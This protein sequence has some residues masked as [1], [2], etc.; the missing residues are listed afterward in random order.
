MPAINV[1][2]TDTFE[3]QRIKINEISSQIFAIGQGGSDL[4]TGN[5]KLGDGSI[6]VPSLTFTNDTTLGLYRPANGV[7]QWAYNSKKL[8]DIKADSI[9]S[10]RDL[11]VEQSAINANGI[12]IF[13]AGSNYDAGTYSAIN[14]NGGSG[15]G[16]FADIVVTAYAGTI[17]EDGENY[18]AGTYTDIA[19]AGGN[20]SGALVSFVVPPIEGTITNAGS[21]YAPGTYS[22]ISLTTTGGVGSGATADIEITG[23]TTYTGTIA[24]SGS[25]YAEDTYESVNT[26]N[27]PTTTYTVTSVA[28]PGTP[29]PDN[30][31]QINGSTQPTLSLIRGNTYRFDVSDA[32]VATH[33]LSFTQVGGAPLDINDY[34]IQTSGVQ[35]EAGSFVDLV[36]KETA[37]IGNIEYICTSHDNMGAQ[38]GVG[39]GVVGNDGTGGVVTIAVNASGNVSSVT[40][41]QAGQGYAAGDQIQVSVDS[42]GGQGSGFL[43]TINSIVYTGIVSNVVIQGNGQNYETGDTLSINNA[44]TGNSGSGFEFTITSNPGS[45]TDLE[46]SEKGTNYQTGDTLSL[47]GQVTGLNVSLPGETT[48][49]AA[50]L[51]TATP[52]VTVASTAN[53]I[54]GMSVETGPDDTGELDAGTTVASIING[55]TIQLS[56]NPTNSG[57]ATLSFSSDSTTEFAVLSTTGIIIGSTITASGNGQLA[58][59]TT[60]ESV[61]SENNTIGISQPPDAAGTATLTIT[62]PFGDPGTDWQYEVGTLGVIESIIASGPGTGYVGGDVLTINDVDLAQP[63]TKVVTNLALI[64]LT[65]SNTVTSTAFQVGDTIIESTSPDTTATV[66]FIKTTGGNID[67]MLITQLTVDSGQSINIEGNAQTYTVGTV[68]DTNRYYIDGALTPNLTLYVGDTYRFDYSDGSN[69]GHFFA[70]SIF[71]D[72]NHSPSLVSVAG[73]S[74]VGASDLITVS[75]T[76]GIQVGMSVAVEA[77][78]GTLQNGTLVSE[79]VDGTTVR[80]DR[81]ALQG[82]SAD[83]VFAGVEYTSGVDRQDNYVDIKITDATPSLYYYCATEGTEHE[84]EA[85]ADNEEAVITIDPNN[86]RV[87]GSGAEFIV[88]I[89]D[90]TNVFSADVETG[91]VSTTGGLTTTDINSTSVTNTG[92]VASATVTVETEIT[93]PKVKSTGALQLEASVSNVTGNFNVGQNLQITADTGNF[94][95]SGELKTTGS[96]N[97]NDLLFIADNDISTPANT[98]ISFTPPTG[99]VAKVISTG[100]LTIPS[101]TTAERPIVGI[102][103]NGSIRFNTETGQYEGYSEATTQWSSLG[104]VRDL[105]GNT[106]IKAEESVGSNDNTLWFINDDDLTVKF[107][108]TKLEFVQNKT[109]SSLNQSAPAY[110]DWNANTPVTLGQYLKYKQNLYEVTGAGTTAGSASPPTHNSGAVV[111]G[112]ATLTFWGLA[113][114]ALTFEDITEVRVG[115]TDDTALVVNADLRL[116]ENKVI[117]DVSDLVFAPNTG[118]KIVVDAKTSLVLPTGLTT[119]RGIP[120]QGSVRFNTQDNIFEGY[121]GT[122][123]GSLGGVKDVDQDTYITP[124]VSAGSD[125]DVLYFY[126]ANNNTL[127]LNTQALDFYTIDTVRSLTSDEFELTASLLTID[128]AATTLD[129]GRS[130]TTFLHS[131]KQ[132]FEIG[133]SYGLGTDTILKLD[134]QGDLFFNTGF[135]SGSKTELKLLNK[136]LTEFELT[137]F[138]VFTEKVN[139]IKGTTDNGVSIVYDAAVHEGA[140]VT[141]VAHNTSTNSKEFFE[142]GI[143]DDGTNVFYTEYGNIATGAKIVDLDFDFTANSTGR[144]NIALNSAVLATQIVNITVVSHITKK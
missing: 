38:I 61:N 135:A 106:Y 49:V 102:I 100:A 65:F 4:A 123:W 3:Q 40:W 75:A 36:I 114:A 130:D 45:V 116:S 44:D 62:P 115:P 21:A 96:V 132:F 120:L 112:G 64:K 46:F 119:D 71:R 51:S 108:P 37:P 76:S 90:T 82:G 97:V 136:E 59:G 39:N 33:P 35:G 30:V 32:S 83:L 93:T 41:E 87:F 34:V 103:S 79:I 17:L 98:D 28:N 50:T 29:P 121:D 89:V 144:L 142:F 80:I 19:L 18:V 125:E 91:L 8:L 74:I 133:M 101:G 128:Q 72:G 60:V 78:A 22:G 23:T 58:A 131:S 127:Q 56:A 126:N 42:I 70:F 9:T 134:N 43:Y 137:D 16:S 104:G 92:D 48:G 85:G 140:R 69:S 141:V 10:Y 107:T 31:Y 117:T 26:F 88:A 52:N 138:K 55:T 129:N 11:I 57:A 67:Y 122:N 14:L 109:I 99:R 13:N 12:S 124:E 68:S 84:D 7:A 105:D 5:L 143:I 77:G 111:N 25:G 139:L 47:P 73:A 113:T 15:S 1:A 6:G 81:A 86:T 118:K 63:I 53:I 2:R 24:N 54:E 27:V 94:V 95:T 66:E 20:G 110:S